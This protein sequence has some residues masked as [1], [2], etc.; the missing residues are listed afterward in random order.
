MAVLRA[1][2]SAQLVAIADELETLRQ[3]EKLT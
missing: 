3:L 2:L 1:Q